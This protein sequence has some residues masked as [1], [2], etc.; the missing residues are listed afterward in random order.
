[1]ALLQISPI[2]YQPHIV[3]VHPKKLGQ[4]VILRM[5]ECVRTADGSR[6]GHPANIVWDGLRYRWDESDEVKQQWGADMTGEVRP[7]DDELSFEVTMRNIGDKPHDGGPFLFCMQAGGHLDFQDY[8]GERTFVH[9]GDRWS[10]VNEMQQGEFE[11]H[12]MCG[13]QRQRDGI[14]HSLMARV[15]TEGDWVLGIA[16]DQ[17]GGVSSNHQPWPSCIHAN[18]VWPM[19]EPGETATA[20]G[21]V[22][23]FRGEIEELYDRYRED[24]SAD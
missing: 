17:D 2:A 16:L 24:V 23:F 20:R 3:I 14:A 12:R 1:M 8:H 19:V 15:N 18:P 10:S 11:D 6:T 4:C 5:P 22:Y 21:K 7:G 13:Y 9:M